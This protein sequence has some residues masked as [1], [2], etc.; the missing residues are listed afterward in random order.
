MA[1]IFM[2]GQVSK[3]YS[4]GFKFINQDPTSYPQ[5]E[6]ERKE[7]MERRQENKTS[8]SCT[9]LSPSPP[10]SLTKTDTVVFIKKSCSLSGDTE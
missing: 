3:A 7:L 9:G 2:Q 1:L 8:P 10:K 6:S 5:P 4:I